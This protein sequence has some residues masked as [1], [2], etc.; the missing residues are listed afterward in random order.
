MVS[1]HDFAALELW[2]LN[3][4][5]VASDDDRSTSQAM[6]QLLDVV[7]HDI[8]CMLCDQR[9]RNGLLEVD[10]LVSQTVASI[11]SA[12]RNG[13]QGRWRNWVRGIGRRRIAD[14]WRRRSRQRRLLA[15]LQTSVTECYV[16]DCWEHAS[17]GRQAALQRLADAVAGMLDEHAGDSV[18]RRRR[19]VLVRR[20]VHRQ[21]FAQIAAA[22]GAPLT[23]VMSIYRRG[24]V[25]LRR[26]L[27]PMEP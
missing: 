9:I 14:E 18:S 12:K 3:P 2:F 7:R 24:V 20:L 21:S 11:L 6:R 16:Q 5:G 4:A 19:S 27:G 13:V 25:D 10:E 17:G 1:T 15:V 26:R 22:E 23:T 8:E